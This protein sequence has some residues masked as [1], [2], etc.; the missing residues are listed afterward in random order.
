[1]TKVMTANTNRRASEKA[2]GREAKTERHGAKEKAR[3]NEATGGGVAARAMQ[4]IDGSQE[5][6]GEQ[7]KEEAGWAKCDRQG[8]C[9]EIEPCGGRAKRT[10]TR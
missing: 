6:G 9:E 4:K 10:K 3:G 7:T 1:M 8:K 5:M 2:G